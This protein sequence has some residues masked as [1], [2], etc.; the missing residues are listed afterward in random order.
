MQLPRWIPQVPRPSDSTFA[1]AWDAMTPNERRVS[2]LFDA[3]LVAFVLFVAWR[4]S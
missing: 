1:R 3:V 4:L 2:L